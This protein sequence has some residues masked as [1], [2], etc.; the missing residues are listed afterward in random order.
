MILDA[1]EEIITREGV[2]KLTARQI[3]GHIGYTVGSIYMIFP[4]MSHLL[5]H[6]NG[7]TLDDIAERLTLV[8][9]QED[10]QKEQCLEELTKAY[11]N[12]ASRNFNRWHIVFNYRPDENRTTDIDWFQQRID[13]LTRQFAIPLHQLAPERSAP[14]ITLAARSLWASVHGIGTLFLVGKPHATS[15]DHLNDSGVL[16]VRNFIRGWVNDGVIKQL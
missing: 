14:E 11:L 12:Y 7:N 10:T 15:P 2:G 8:R 1:T 16:L 9:Q 6:F 4:S 3:A 5:M 13:T